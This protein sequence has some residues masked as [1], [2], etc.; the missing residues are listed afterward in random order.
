MS[1]ILIKEMEEEDIDQVCKIEEISFSTPWTKEALTMEVT[2]NNLAKYLV[3]KKEDKVVGYAGVWIIIDE[4]HITNIAVSP[5]YRGQG[6][7]S[8][9]VEKL[10]KLCEE[11]GISNMTLEVRESNTTAQSLYKK[12]GFEEYGIRPN[13]YSDNNENALIMWRKDK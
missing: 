6:I 5:D 10:V 11:K 1:N 3:A 2:K 9:L 12:F 7:G 13:Y 4:G 8:L